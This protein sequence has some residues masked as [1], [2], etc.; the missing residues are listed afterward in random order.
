MTLDGLMSRWMMP[1]WW[2]C[3]IA[4]HTGLDDLEGD[5]ALDRLGLLG[6]EDGAHAALADLLQQPVGADD[7]AQGLGR[8]HA[9][10]G[11]FVRVVRGFQEAAELL[12]LPEQRF[13]ALPGV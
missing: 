1:F 9:D 12:V 6:H 11:G 10:A 3:W 5:L 7:R 13:H 8:D 4:W 2:A